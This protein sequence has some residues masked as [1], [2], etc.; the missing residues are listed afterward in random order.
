ML[1][2][3]PKQRPED[4]LLNEEQ[5]PRLNQTFYLSDPS[6]YFERRLELLVMQAGNWDGVYELLK[7]GVTFGKVT[8]KDDG[9]PPDEDAIRRR[10]DH[11]TTAE[12]ELLSH[13]I[14]EALLRLYLAHAFAG[15]KPPECPRL[16]LARLRDAGDFRKLIDRRFGDYATIDNL[17]NRRAL[18][19][20][21][22]FSDDRLAFGPVIPDATAW[23]KS[24]DL[25]EDYLRFFARQ[26][27]DGSSMYN[28]AKH[29]LA[30]TTGESGI[31][32]KGIVGRHGPSIRYLTVSST[33]S[34]PR[35]RWWEMVHWVESDKQV[36]FIH[37]ACVML[38]NLWRVARHRYV[39]APRTGFKLHLL[40][41]PSSM[42]LIVKDS[43]DGMVLHDAGWQLGY[44]TDE[45]RRGAR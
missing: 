40:S 2:R 13:Q 5:F 42:D 30:L 25:H 41:G 37:R 3:M 10:G 20:V 9:E 7:Q 32:L 43:K 1:V 12:A 35:P 36:V 21:F 17:E 8:I 34:S 15:R 19:R 6:D 22:H 26:H 16:D 39:D 29:G 11:F 23:S 38:R 33:K 4:H 28:A 45:P 27:L 24:L 31:E 14:G 18:A 44:W